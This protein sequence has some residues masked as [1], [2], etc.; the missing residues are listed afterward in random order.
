M[1]YG[2]GPVSLG[3]YV[4]IE[5]IDDTVIDSFFGDDSGNIYEGEGPGTSL[6]EGTANQ[7]Q[8]SFQKENNEQDADWSDVEALYNVLHSEERTSDP[9]AWRE[10]L[11]SIF[12]VDTF[13]EWLSISAVIEH[14]DSYGSMSHNFYLYNDPDTGLL[15]W[16]SWDHNEVLGVAGGGTRGNTS[17]GKEEVGQNWPLIRYLLDDPVY[18]D[19]YI[20]YIGETING[21]FNPETLERKC[22]EL[23]ELIAPYAAKESSEA[24][25]ES[26]VQELIDRIYE[27]YQATTTFL[28]TGGK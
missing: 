24:A 12:D 27:R 15:T 25:F 8:T 6:A 26:A 7:I 17:L 3:L 22:E 23:A 13:L 4:A 14:W 2:D 20:D 10:S 21:V 19:L 11:E 1:D 5:V 28:A 9:E 18:Y 16:I